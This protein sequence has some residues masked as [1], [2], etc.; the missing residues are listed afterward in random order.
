VTGVTAVRHAIGQRARRWIDRVAGAALALFG[1]AE[2][3][4]SV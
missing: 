2:I 4:R 1:A 3:R